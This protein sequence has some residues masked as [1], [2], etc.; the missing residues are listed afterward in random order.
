MKGGGG[1]I[2][3]VRRGWREKHDKYEMNTIDRNLNRKEITQH[4][5]Y[6]NEREEDNTMQ[7]LFKV[8][9]HEESLRVDQQQ[10][11]KNMHVGRSIVTF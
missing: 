1:R 4:P 2:E 11:G 3:E 9:T 7:K 8:Y 5:A 6:E 10:K